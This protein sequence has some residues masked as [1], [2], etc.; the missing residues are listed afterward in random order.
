MEYEPE[1]TRALQGL[2]YYWANDNCGL[3][4][5][6]QPIPIILFLYIVFLNANPKFLVHSATGQ[7][8]LAASKGDSQ[9]KNARKSAMGKALSFLAL[10]LLSI[11]SIKR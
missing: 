4:S 5:E 10:D 2:S 9:P 3:G 6:H 1:L 7:C 8:K 11:A